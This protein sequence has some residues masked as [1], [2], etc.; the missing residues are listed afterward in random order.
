MDHMK[1]DSR[2][3]PPLKYSSQ[4]SISTAN[5]TSISIIGE[6]SLSLTNT[7]NLDSVLVVPSMNYNVRPEKFQ[8]QE[9]W[10]DCNFDYKVVNFGKKYVI[11]S[12]DLG[13]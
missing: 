2:Q 6:G 10:Q 12:L 8:F 3:V 5:G 4:N 7:L 11:Y 1:F 13:C 9:K